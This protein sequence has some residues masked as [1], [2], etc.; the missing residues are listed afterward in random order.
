MI[1]ELRTYT[2]KPGTRATAAAAFEKLLPECKRLGMK[3]AGPWL[4]VEDDTKLFW[5][6]GFPDAAARSAMSAQF[7][8]GAAW[9]NELSGIFMPILEKY[10][11]TAVEMDEA[12]V[13]WV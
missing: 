8:G 11:V 7:Y 13:K 3:V 12:A 2:M 5:M 4:S 6:R 1:V 9:K 10:E